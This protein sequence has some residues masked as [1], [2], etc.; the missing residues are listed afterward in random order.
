MITYY[1]TLCMIRVAC[2]Q[3][4]MRNIESSVLTVCKYRYKYDQ[5]YKCCSELHALASCTFNCT[6][7][8]ELTILTT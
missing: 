1:V 5:V 7:T 3:W 2:R 6:Y 8:N 4:C